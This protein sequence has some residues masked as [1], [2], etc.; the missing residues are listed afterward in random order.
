[1][2]TAQLIAQVTSKI[3]SIEGEL[4]NLRLW[5]QD[6]SLDDKVEPV[7]PNK[8]MKSIDSSKPITLNAFLRSLPSWRGAEYVDR[9][10]ANNTRKVKARPLSDKDFKKLQDKVKGHPDVISLDNAFECCSGSRYTYVRLILKLKDIP[11]KIILS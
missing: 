7:T 2:K 6:L 10:K 11:T 1:M 9:S 5:L 3:S 4:T 8:R